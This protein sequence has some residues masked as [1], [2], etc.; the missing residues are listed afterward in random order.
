MILKRLLMCAALAS[1][2]VEPEVLELKSSLQLPGR[3]A[4]GSSPST[5]DTR[6]LS[7]SLDRCET[8]VDL[9][10]GEKVHQFGPGSYGFFIGDGRRYVSVQ[11]DELSIYSTDDWSSPQRVLPVTADDGQPEL[12]GPTPDGLYGLFREG[13]SLLT[14]FELVEPTG[15]FSKGVRLAEGGWV[16]PGEFAISPGERFLAVIRDGILEVWTIAQNRLL[17]AKRIGIRTERPVMHVRGLLFTQEADL[18]MARNSFGGPIVF[19]Q[20][21]N[22][23]WVES[24]RVVMPEYVADMILS[25]S[26]K[27]LATIVGG[28]VYMHRLPSLEIEG[29]TN[30]ASP[31]WKLIHLKQG[32]V[33]AL[34]TDPEDPQHGPTVLKTF[35]TAALN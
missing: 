17:Y 31:C 25:D 29:T 21:R 6:L 28:D 23:Q 27:L 26:S 32:E 16:F 24:A 2:G 35:S 22:T 13:S 10:S 20:E 5:D 33:A 15:Q 7:L 1:A 30:E 11:N 4:P 14:Y 8:I 12:F 34:C 3:V 19:L 9:N 18:V